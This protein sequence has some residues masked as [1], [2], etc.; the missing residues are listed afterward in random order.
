VFK[1]AIK[2]YKT[3]ILNFEQSF[4]KEIRSIIKTKEICVLK[5]L[6]AINL[7]IY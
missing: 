4:Y 5:L 7:N 1:I 3:N 2:L 6:I